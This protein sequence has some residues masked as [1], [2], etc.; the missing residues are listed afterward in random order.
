MLREILQ[1]EKLHRSES[2]IYIK[3]I[4]EEINES[5]IFLFLLFLTDLK[6]NRLFEWIIVTMN[7]VTAAY[8]LVK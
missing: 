7:W 8:G 2:Q 3:S 5:K 1:E 6:Y 4:K